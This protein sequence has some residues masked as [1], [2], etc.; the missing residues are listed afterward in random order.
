MAEK[1]ISIA[2]DFTI[3]TG[4]RFKVPGDDFSGE[5]FREDHIVPNLKKFD[6]L[7]INMAGTR[8]YGSSFLEESFGGLIRVRRIPYSELE[9]K[10][11]IFSDD[12][13]YQKYVERAKKYIL[14][15]SKNVGS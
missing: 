7:K 5:A 2:N 11:I 14:D 9:K 13:A 10:L 15:A 3:F 4:G 8:G 6:L 1:T 12:P